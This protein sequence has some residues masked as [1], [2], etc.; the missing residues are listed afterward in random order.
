MRSWAEYAATFLTHLVTPVESRYQCGFTRLRGNSLQVS[1]RVSSRA[2][3]GSPATAAVA[4][5]GVE[6]KDLLSFLQ[7]VILN[8]AKDLLFVR[9]ETNSAASE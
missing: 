3:P 8:E 2:Q 7:G 9:I 4:V 5:V 6:A 1:N